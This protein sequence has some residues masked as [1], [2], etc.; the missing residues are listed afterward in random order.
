[1][2]SVI[3][4]VI[5]VLSLSWAIVSYDQKIGVVEGIEKPNNGDQQNPSTIIV[6]FESNDTI[7]CITKTNWTKSAI[8]FLANISL[9]GKLKRHLNVYLFPILKFV[10]NL[11][12]SV[13]RILAL[14]LFASVY[15]WIIW[16]ACLAHL[17]P[18]FVWHRTKNYS[19]TDSLRFSILHVITYLLP[20]KNESDKEKHPRISPAAYQTVS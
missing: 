5:S 13:G 20:A 11:L 8:L 15:G 9:M 4:L 7:D 1:V 17:I 10:Q 19:F 14:S 18:I 2:F 12:S 16:P 3:C 6:D